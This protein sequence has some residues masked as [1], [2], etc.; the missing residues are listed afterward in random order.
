LSVAIDQDSS[1]SRINGKV[2]KAKAKSKAKGLCMDR[3][4]TPEVAAC[5][6][7]TKTLTSFNQGVANLAKAKLLLDEMLKQA[8][9]KYGSHAE[10]MVD[11]RYKVAYMR[12]VM[13]DTL[14]SD[15][16]GDT[17]AETTEKI[18]VA[19]TNDYFA[20]LFEISSGGN[21][22]FVVQT[23][24]LMKE[25]RATMGGLES[26]AVVSSCAADHV[27]AIELLVEVARAGKLAS[28]QWMSNVLARDK[29]L[30][31]EQKMQEKEATRQ[32][33][34]SQTAAKKQEK[35]EERAL[36]KEARV[37]D[38]IASK[39]TDSHGADGAPAEKSRRIS[40]RIAGQIEQ[41]DPAVLSLKKANFITVVEDAASFYQAILS[42]RSAVFRAR[43]GSIAKLMEFNDAPG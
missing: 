24:A 32:L 35:T 31:E 28:E 8:I 25:I 22:A 27:K 19:M 15:G 6:I 33:K 9:A 39:G 30:N 12:S 4:G 10:A 21:S 1:G 17:A 26:V 43:K 7:R 14:M 20:V 36:A 41:S 16:C 18:M 23:V 3:A 11:R 42:G 38:K 34:E 37:L 5:Q 40:F 29:A 2:S 13:V